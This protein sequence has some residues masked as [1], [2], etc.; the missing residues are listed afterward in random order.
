[1]TFLSCEDCGELSAKVR[2]CQGDMHLCT[3]CNKKRFGGGNG[4]KSDGDRGQVR[5][6]SSGVII[7][8]L[9][10]FLVNKMDALTT[11]MLV[12]LCCDHFGDDEVE[13]AK[14][15]LFEFC[16]NDFGRLVKRQGQNKRYNNVMD[17]VKLL[18][19]LDEEDL[20]CFVAKNLAKLPPVDINHIDVST[21]MTELKFM[22][23]ELSQLKDNNARSEVGDLAD[24]LHVL[25][26]EIC[27]MKGCL[28]NI[29]LGVE[30]RDKIPQV[31][32]RDSAETSVMKLAPP[33]SNEVWRVNTNSYAEAVQSQVAVGNVTTNTALFPPRRAS[34]GN[35]E[36]PSSNQ[37]GDFK[38]VTRRPKRRPQHVIGTAK[39]VEGCSLKVVRPNPPFKLFITR[40]SPTTTPEDV[41]RYIESRCKTEVKCEQLTTKY[42]TYKSF[43]I[44]TTRD[45]AD[46][47]RDPALWPDGILVRKFY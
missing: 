45:F 40:F 30:K 26:Q 44:E 27:E 6:T 36:N 20:P 22:R 31:V 14:K 35:L 42:D 10:C 11:D 12:K 8:E 24:E 13:L 29:Q 9:L 38:L 46:A 7:N 39:P 28:G 43:V 4:S 47:V 18:H 16:H 2:L 1:M 17:M 34:S 23:R 37:K 19:E 32:C 15:T 25:R 21:L 33:P 5:T 3:G 41:K